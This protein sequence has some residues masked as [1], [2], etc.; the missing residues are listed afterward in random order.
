[1][2]I[3]DIEDNR[4]YYILA[5]SEE[6][7]DEI[8][9]TIKGHMDIINPVDIEVTYKL[10][11]SSGIFCRN[12]DLNKYKKMKRFKISLD[13]LYRLSDEIYSNDSNPR[14]PRARNVRDFINPGRL[15]NSQ[16]TDSERI[17]FGS[18]KKDLI[19]IME[20]V[21]HTNL[22]QQQFDNRSHTDFPRNNDPNVRARQR[23]QTLIDFK[24]DNLVPTFPGYMLGRGY[25][26]VYTWVD[27][28]SNFFIPIHKFIYDALPQFFR[29]WYEENLYIL[30]PEEELREGLR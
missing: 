3:R 8:L 14:N 5:R 10:P 26:R 22:T 6:E 19:S 15:K 16:L 2:N 13:N 4:R 11:C 20:D 7:A 28:R 25:E 1:M 18:L 9:G 23:L 30:E 21:E 12:E 27:G 29:T 17:S 24:N